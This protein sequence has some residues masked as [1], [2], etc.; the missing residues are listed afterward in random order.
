MA[1]LL[2]KWWAGARCECKKCGERFELEASDE[3]K[4]YGSVSF[5]ACPSC[6]VEM[7][8]E[9]PLWKMAGAWS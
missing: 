6:G 5:I 3:L 4:H 7:K 1:K 9:K 2:G 8:V